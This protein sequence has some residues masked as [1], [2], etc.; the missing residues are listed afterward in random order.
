[1]Y[2]Y[3]FTGEDVSEGDELGSL[4]GPQYTF[5]D[6]ETKSHFTNYSMSSSVIR[7]NDQLTLLDD[8]FEE[9]MNFYAL[10]CRSSQGLSLELA[11]KLSCSGSITSTLFNCVTF[12]LRHYYGMGEKSF[13]KSESNMNL[14]YVS[15]TNNFK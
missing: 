8:C 1:M 14:Y 2:C 7:R 9:V 11:C 4:C 6:E 10:V 13:K 3:S 5:T 12:V 15:E